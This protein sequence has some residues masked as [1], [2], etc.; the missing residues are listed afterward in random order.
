[1][2]IKVVRKVWVTTSDI[3]FKVMINAYVEFMVDCLSHSLTYNW[4]FTQYK[5]NTLSINASKMYLPNPKMKMK[6]YF[7]NTTQFD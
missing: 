6:A 3:F 4:N 7:I 2:I 1:M 5:G